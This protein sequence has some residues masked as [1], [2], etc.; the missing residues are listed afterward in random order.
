MSRHDLIAPALI[1]DLDIEKRNIE[2]M[3]K[4]LRAHRAKLRPHI[5]GQKFPELARMQIEA[6]AIGVCTETVWEAIV[7]SR[8]GSSTRSMVKPTEI[9]VFR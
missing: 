8:A 7:M 1:L 5:E 6:G 9:S 2:R 4:S 3:T